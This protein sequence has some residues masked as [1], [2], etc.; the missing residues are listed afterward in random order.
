M[1][2]FICPSIHPSIHLL[3]YPQI[4]IKRSP[5][6]GDPVGNQRDTTL[7]F[8]APKGSQGRD[9]FNIGLYY[10]ALS[11]NERGRSGIHRTLNSTEDNQGGASQ[12]MPCLTET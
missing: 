7:A 11:S 8:L 12:N 3:A 2:P 9:S 1:L 4:N 5:N 6:T 10:N